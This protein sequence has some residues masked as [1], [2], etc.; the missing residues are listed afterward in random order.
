MRLNLL[1]YLITATTILT[2]V[3]PASAEP[4]K[5]GID[6]STQYLIAANNCNALESLQPLIL[7]KVNNNVAGQSHRISRR[8]RLVINHLKDISFNGCSMN[9]EMDVTLKRKFRRDAHGTVKVRADI[10]NFSYKQ[11]CYQNA[12]VT[13]VNLS[14]TLRIGEAAYKWVANKVLPNGQCLS[15]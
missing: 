10:T 9:I 8:K 1:T 6:D 3:L 13:D 12:K 15:V 14:R 7:R 11:L 2:P 5:P 4:Y